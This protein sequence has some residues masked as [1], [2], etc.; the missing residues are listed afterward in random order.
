MSLLISIPTFPRRQDYPATAP[1]EGVLQR[2]V[3]LN[4]LSTVLSN[5]EYPIS[6]A[7]AA[8]ECEGIVV[9]LA[10]ATV[11]L[12]DTILESREDQFTSGEDLE[13]ELMSLLPRSAVGEPF[14]SEGDA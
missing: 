3:R 1:F 11:N 12:N 7:T 13:L 2:I 4:R 6:P 8:R 14:Q 5:L 10:E 9:E